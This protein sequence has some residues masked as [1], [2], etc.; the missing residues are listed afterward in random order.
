MVSASLFSLVLLATTALAVPSRL[1]DRVSRRRENGR[2]SRPV[3]D[4]QVAVS[5]STQ[6]AQ[7]Q[8]SS[9]WSGAVLVAN[10]VSFYYSFL[11][12]SF[13]CCQN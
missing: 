11:F 4:L 12:L 5:N 13:F 1:S 3:Q 10:S 7:A 6:G 9:N 8:Y 2:R